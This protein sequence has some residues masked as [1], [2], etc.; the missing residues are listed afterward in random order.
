VDKQATTLR[1]FFALWPDSALQ[2]ALHN[3]GSDLN[4]GCGGRGVRPETIHL[5]LAFIGALPADRLEALYAAAVRVNTPAFDWQ[6]DQLGYWR[7]NQLLWAG[8]SQPPEALSRLVSHLHA[9]LNDAGLAFDD[10]K[11]FAPHI[12]L[13]RKAHCKELVQPP[14]ALYWQVREFVLV[15]SETT[16]KGASYRVIRRWPLV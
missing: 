1:V 7:R 16:D 10:S 13:L 11:P 6:V 9:A 3:L 12:T 14:Q 5:T 8:T 4:A 15:Q 2:T